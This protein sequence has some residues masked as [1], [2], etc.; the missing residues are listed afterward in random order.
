MMLLL[1]ELNENEQN[2][3]CSTSESAITSTQDRPKLKTSFKSK[4][5]K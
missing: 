3:S 5:T 4:Q 2:K 1:K